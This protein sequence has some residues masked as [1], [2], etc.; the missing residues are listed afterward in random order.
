MKIQFREAVPDDAEACGR[1][2]YD[3]FKT[4]AYHH[5]FPPDWPSPE[6]ATQVLA[7]FIS[8]SKFFG[9]VAEIDGK[10]AGSNFLDERSCITGIGPIT[11]DLKLQNNQIGRQLMNIVLDRVDER[12]HPGVRLVQAA[13]HNRSFS[14]Y[15]KLGFYVKEQLVTIQG[16]PPKIQIS[17]YTVRKAKTSDLVMCNNLCKR[18]HGHNRSGE[19]LDAINQGSATIVEHDKRITGYC[20]A[21][22]FLGHAVGES[23]NDL[24]ALICSVNEFSGPGF[25]LPSR[26]GELLTWCLENGLKVV[27]LMTLM[28]K[29]LYNEPSG[30]YLPSVLY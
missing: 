19:L 25:L 2:C 27:Q 3:A 20:S 5:N 4:L 8:H 30:V 28:S 6:I 29:G 24:R 21:I 13:Y 17:G 15:S 23:N 1:I 11:V 7:G 12:G 22:G 18:V 16:Q 14:L 10:I 26:N 9:I